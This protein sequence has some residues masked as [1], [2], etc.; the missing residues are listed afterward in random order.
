MEIIIPKS[1]DV[2]YLIINL[3]DDVGY[4]YIINQMNNI[5]E[6]SE[7]I[8]WFNAFKMIIED[9]FFFIPKH[10]LIPES[11]N[12]DISHSNIKRIIDEY[13]FQKLP[14]FKKLENI[15]FKAFLNKKS[16][17]KQGIIHPSRTLVTRFKYMMNPKSLTF[18]YIESYN[19]SYTITFRNNVHVK[20]KIIDDLPEIKELKFQFGFFDI[21]MPA[22]QKNIDIEIDGRAKEFVHVKV[23]DDEETFSR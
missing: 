15:L 5:L 18:E 4:E 17:R 21:K 23:V 12:Y 1:K 8:S 13:G 19:N 7:H 11:E 22:N 9:L 3:I 16:L 20:A 2:P 6:K 10:Q 14:Y